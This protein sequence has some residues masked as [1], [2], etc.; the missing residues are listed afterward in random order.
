[1]R[2]AS[3]ANSAIGDGRGQIDDKRHLQID[4]LSLFKRPNAAA[5]K[6]DAC[7]GAA[8]TPTASKAR[9]KKRP[10]D[11]HGKAAITMG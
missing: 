10:A 9:A 6:T 5:V 7:I 8:A 3:E 2:H 1:M 4:S 11:G